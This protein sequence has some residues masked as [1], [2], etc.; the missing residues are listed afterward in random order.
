MSV[1]PASRTLAMLGWSISAS[2]WRSASKRATTWAVSMP[3]LMTLSAT[4]RRTGCL[5][6]GHVDDAHPPLADLLEQLVGADELPGR[7]DR[8]RW[9]DQ[10]GRRCGRGFEEAPGLEVGLD[11]PLQA[12]TQPLVLA[13]GAG[14][15]RGACLGR[16]DLDR[17]GEDGVESG[18]VVR[19][20]GGVLRTF[21]RETM[22]VSRRGGIITDEK[23]FNRGPSAGHRP[24]PRRARR[25][26]PPSVAWP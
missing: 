18:V 8:G 12:A 16:R 4:R 19:A 13:A 5:L 26:R 10:V 6:L 17:L 22:R 2:A 3:G 11:Q 7:L 9:G 25:G 15:E 21:A 1:A 23:F 14:Q 24:G 20:I